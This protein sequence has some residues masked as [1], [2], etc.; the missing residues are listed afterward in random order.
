M[1]K[2]VAAHVGEWRAIAVLLAFVLRYCLIASFPLK[3]EHEMKFSRRQFHKIVISAGS[4]AVLPRLASAFDYPTRPVR[5]IC[6][7]V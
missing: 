1:P 3:L 4:V 6:M 2:N 5:I 7:L